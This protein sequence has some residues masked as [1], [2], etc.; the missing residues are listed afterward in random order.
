MI[1]EARIWPRVGF[2]EDPDDGEDYCTAMLRMEHLVRIIEDMNRR[3]P[4][5]VSSPT[6]DKLLGHEPTWRAQPRFFEY[7]EQ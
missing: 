2:E 5:T 4:E 3:R 1:D 6:I 7:D